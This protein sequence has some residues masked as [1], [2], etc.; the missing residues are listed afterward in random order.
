MKQFAKFMLRL[1]GWKGVYE[2][3][4][5]EQK[6]IIIGAPH[7]SAWDFVISWLYYTSAGKKAN[8]LIKK[9][10]FFWPLGFFVKKM[11]GLPI[12]RSKGSNVIR[13]TIQLFKENDYIHLALTPE[14][15]R[16]RTTKWKAGFH[17]IAKET[18]VPV[19]LGAFDWGK[20]EISIDEK[21]EISDDSS[22][23]I[24]RMKTYYKNKGIKGKVPENFSTDF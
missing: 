23:D 20:K 22:A 13:Q 17:I 19:Y 3:I 1:V 10:F 12:D 8:V 24:K 18:G 14:G 4:P 2:G 7:T 16:K 15:T 9:E 11:G 21:F 5:T 6:C